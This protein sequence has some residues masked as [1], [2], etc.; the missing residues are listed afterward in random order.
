MSSSNP[1][2]AATL[3]RQATGLRAL[4][5]AILAG[6]TIDAVPDAAIQEGLTAFAT[7]Y[8]AKCDA[9]AR[10]SPFVPD[11]GVTA[12]TVMFLTSAMLRAVNVELFELGMWKAFSGA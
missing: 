10:F 5:D 7:L 2:P 8:A 9:G 3:D 1:D 12:T 6:G 4:A 11:G